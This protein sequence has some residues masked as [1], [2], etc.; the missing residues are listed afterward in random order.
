MPSRAPLFS[1]VAEFS[2]L[3]SDSKDNQ[4]FAFDPLSDLWFRLPPVP[5]RTDGSSPRN[6]PIRIQVESPVYRR[7]RRTTA[8]R[9]LIYL[10]R[11]TIR[12]LI[13]GSSIRHWP[14]ISGP[15]SP[16]ALSLPISS[17]TMEFLEISVMP[18]D[19]RENGNEMRWAGESDL[20]DLVA[21]SLNKEV[22]ILS[23]FIGSPQI[24][25]LI[26]HQVAAE[27]DGKCSVYNLVLEYAAGGSL[28]DLINQ[29]KKLPEDE[30]K[31]YLRMM[32]TGFSCIHSK[33]FVHCDFKPSNVLVFPSQHGNPDLK[34][35][36]FGLSKM[37]MKEQR[38]KSSFG[39]KS[40][41]RGTREYMSPKSFIGDITP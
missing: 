8:R 14:R 24:L 4:F 26:G 30:L 27:D 3:T 39:Y 2:N 17:K 13:F 36:D 18:S 37:Y 7:R 38:P 15:E 20:P 6:F 33:G 21:Y 22:L 23:K 32:L 35:A 19:L 12:T 41:F 28:D 11:F 29:R 31:G 10:S 1:P 16:R 25:Q 40:S 5:I 9:P 34:I